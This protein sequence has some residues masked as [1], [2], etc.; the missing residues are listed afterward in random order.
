MTEFI[1]FLIAGASL[2]SLYALIAVGFVVIYKGTGLLNFAQGGLL[3]LGGYL[4]QWLI[5]AIGASFWLALLGSMLATGLVGVAVERSI[6]ARMLG[7][8]DF[9]VIM[10]TWAVLIVLEQV[11]PAIWGY[12]YT[13]M[14]DPWGMATTEL[15]PFVAFSIDL[16]ALFLASLVVLALYLFF[17]FSRIGVGMRATASDPEAS[18]AQG[19]SPRIV[20]ALSWFIAGALAALSGTILGGGSHIVSP[21]LSHVALLAF[22]AIILGGLDSIPG[23][24]IGGILIGVAEVLA[25]AYVPI[26]APWLGQNFHLVLPYI[27]LVVVLL[28]RPYG[29][30]GTRAVRRV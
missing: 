14:N 1:Q 28:I 17:T 15:G 6:I 19:I 22:P 24:V 30:L 29:L 25:S 27:I 20:F 12:D 4:S 16:W 5:N 9:T 7:K 2:G 26:W 18:L 8:P 13:A 11:P 10:I 3:M 23:A 21:E